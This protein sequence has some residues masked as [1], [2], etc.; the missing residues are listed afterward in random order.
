MISDSPNSMSDSDKTP[1]DQMMHISQ[2]ESFTVALKNQP[3][4]P[5]KCNT[6]NISNV[7][8]ECCTA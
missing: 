7:W 4:A 3:K 5:Y 2:H 1:T 6:S 8:T